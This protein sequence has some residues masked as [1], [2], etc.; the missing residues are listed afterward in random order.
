[1][2]SV[3]NKI[4]K[5]VST[6]ENDL[7][8][9]L[10]IPDFSQDIRERDD[11][12]PEADANAVEFEA[13]AVSERP[14]NGTATP[15]PDSRASSI[16]R[17]Q[18]DIDQLREKWSGLEREIEA[19]EKIT[20]DLNAEIDQLNGQLKSALDELE[21]REEITNNLNAEI[22]QLDGKLKS[23]LDELEAREKTSNDLD[24]EIDQL[25][26][27][28]ES[29]LNNHLLKSNNYRRRSRRTNPG[30]ATWKS[31]WQLARRRSACWNCSCKSPGPVK[32]RTMKRLQCATGKL[33]SWRGNWKRGSQNVKR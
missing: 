28:L 22:D 16:D 24:A 11:H 9:E 21:V 12:D 4:N 10:E 33:R 13:S 14:T 6:S 31:S 29:V 7:T 5:L 8:A 27:Q 23:A 26:G 19:K 3:S 17:L 25:N 2:T 30:F 15:E 18:I 20:T 32:K 1:M